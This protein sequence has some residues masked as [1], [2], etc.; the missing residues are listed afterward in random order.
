MTHDWTEAGHYMDVPYYQLFS[1]LFDEKLVEN[2]AIFVFSDHGFRYG[3]LILF[4][5]SSVPDVEELLQ[6]L[7][8]LIRSAT[9]DCPCG[10]L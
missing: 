4:I 8:T 1:T 10:R 5:I 9:N 2:T 3:K 6:S 7:S